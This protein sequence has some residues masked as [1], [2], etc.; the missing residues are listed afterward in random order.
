MT[1]FSS[2]LRPRHARHDRTCTL[3]LPPAGFPDVATTGQ[4]QGVDQ[5]AKA[6]THVVQIVEATK[7]LRRDADLYDMLQVQKGRSGRGWGTPQVTRNRETATN[8]DR[9]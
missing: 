1:C 5:L 9:W 7:D 2:V 3:P 8:R 4:Q 6:F